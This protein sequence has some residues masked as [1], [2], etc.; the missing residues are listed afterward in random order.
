M[1]PFSSKRN[2][3]SLPLPDTAICDAFSVGQSNQGISTGVVPPP[4]P[5]LTALP[6]VNMAPDDGELIPWAKYNLL[7]LV[8]P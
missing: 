4:Y 5:H 6:F 3:G 2:H 8:I 7:P 1:V